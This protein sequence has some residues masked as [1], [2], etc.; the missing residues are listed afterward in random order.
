MSAVVGSA[1]DDLVG[2]ILNKKDDANYLAQVDREF[3]ETEI[4]LL[5]DRVDQYKKDEIAQSNKNGALDARLA[6]EL[7]N[8]KDI[9]M[10]LNGELAKKTDEI[11][12]LQESKMALMDDAE[13]QALEHESRLLAQKD[14]AQLTAAKLQEEIS[15]LKAK[16]DNVSKFIAEKKEME[17][18]LDEQERQIELDAKEH[19]NQVSDLERKHVQEKDRLK[20]E[21]LIKLRETKANLLK[22]TDN[23]LDTTTKR[24]IAENEQMA[25]ELAWQSKET[26][27]LIRRNDKLMAE[28]A[29]LKRELS[30]HKQTEEEF[31]KKVNVYQKTIQTL[32]GKLNT[33]GSEHHA[34]LHRRDLATEDAVR[35]RSESINEREQ[36]SARLEQMERRVYEAEEA[37]RV[38][39]AQLH[40]LG[41]KH[42]NVLMLPNEAVKFTLQCLDDMQTRVA[43]S[44]SVPPTGGA[45]DQPE[46]STLQNLDADKREQ[47]LVY[48][49]DQLNAYQA[50]LKELEMHTAWRQH[51]LAAQQQHMPAPAAVGGEH[52]D[53]GFAPST[54]MAHAPGAL[55]GNVKAIAKDR[56]LPPIF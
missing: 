20:K 34:E 36:L 50:Q 23:Q 42:E 16:L 52:L 40:E 14:A 51:A 54:R 19:T 53:G 39:D 3:L 5:K 22:M 35:D 44:G 27:K 15:T 48:L 10:Y 9:F 1:L 31:A 55:P 28:N 45:A 49:L 47:V 17:A 25:T 37:L 18:R 33:V 13:K 6:N 32:M 24:T 8:Q 21:M 43:G 46:R 30:L 7:A 38:R 4:R 56:L 2:A 41:T 12:E 26:E 11:L 29:N